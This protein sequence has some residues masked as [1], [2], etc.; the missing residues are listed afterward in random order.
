MTIVGQAAAFSAP[1]TIVNA[2]LQEDLVTLSGGSHCRMDG[3][4]AE[5]S[6]HCKTD[7]KHRHCQ[8]TL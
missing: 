5:P 3:A 1:K 7:Q 8:Q 6:P 2:L 4:E